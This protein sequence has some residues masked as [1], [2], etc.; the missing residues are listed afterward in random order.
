MPA[1]LQGS[2]TTQAGAVSPTVNRH[3][4]YKDCVNSNTKDYAFTETTHSSKRAAQ[5]DA[6]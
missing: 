6:A 4:P 2:D 3:L 1:P 5:D